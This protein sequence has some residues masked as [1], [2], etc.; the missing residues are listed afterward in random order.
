MGKAELLAPKMTRQRVDEL[1]RGARRAAPTSNVVMLE[2]VELVELVEAY[3][4]QHRRCA[5]CGFERCEHLSSPA[6]AGFSEE[7]KPYTAPAIEDRPVCTVCMSR[8]NPVAAQNVA[9]SADGLEWFE[10]GAHEATD[11]VAGVVRVELEPLDVW[12]ARHAHISW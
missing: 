6:C 8:S 12:R 11:N 2:A 4:S 5:S 7:R 9:S 3:R 1:E 10:C